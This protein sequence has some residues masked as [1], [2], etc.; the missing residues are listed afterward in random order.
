MT[1]YSC[2]TARGKHSA[3]LHSILSRA[4][5]VPQSS[6]RTFTIVIIM[7]LAHPIPGKFDQ[8]PRV[9]FDK[10]AG[11][12]Q[13]E[14]EQTGQEFEYNEAVQTWLPLV[15]LNIHSLAVESSLLAARR[16]FMESTTSCIFCRRRRRSGMSHHLWFFTPLVISSYTR[17]V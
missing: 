5:H 3:R 9:S 15:S 4:V 11:K 2:A 7:P 17:R 12:W 8:D 14:D 13:Y 1:W 16:E 6:T 10:T